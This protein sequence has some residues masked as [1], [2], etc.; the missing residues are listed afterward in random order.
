MAVVL[1]RDIGVELCAALGLPAAAKISR[2]MI[3]ADAGEAATVTITQFIETNEADGRGT[4][5]KTPVIGLRERGKW[6]RVKAMPVAGTDARTLHQVVQ[7]NVEEGSMLHTDEHGGYKGLHGYDH[8]SVN[9]GAKE[10]V[11]GNVT[12]NGIESVW[13]VM[14][15]GLYCVYHHASEKHLHRYVDEFAFRLNEGNVS[16]HTLDRLDSFVDGVAGKRLTYKALI[17]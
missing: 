2:I 5:G 12:T 11:R 10:Y 7:E 4:V 17:A 8:E 9:H 3:T 15:R 16:R 13:A 14:K 1:G 6:G